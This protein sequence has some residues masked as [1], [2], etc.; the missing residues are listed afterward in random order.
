MN[1]PIAAPKWLYVW[2]R[3][4]RWL[5]VACAL[6]TVAGIVVGF[7]RGWIGGLLVA[8]SVV[9]ASLPATGVRPDLTQPPAFPGQALRASSRALQRVYVAIGLVTAVA[10][11]AAGLAGLPWTAI[12]ATGPLAASLSMVTGPGRAW[13][14]TR[15][16]VYGGR[17]SRLIPADLVGFL[18]FASERALLRRA[19]GGYLFFH[20]GVQRYFADEH[21]DRIGE[22]GR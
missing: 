2:E 14:R 19:G 11:L 4:I 5:P 7:A 13:L 22:G 15:A 21:R 20:D 17:R 1:N 16:L 10:S 3:A 9:I 6:G 8:G 18:E 12:A